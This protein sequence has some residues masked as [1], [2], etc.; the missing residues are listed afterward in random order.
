M[1]K[2]LEDVKVEYVSQY[3]SDL[4]KL[5]EGLDSAHRPKPDRINQIIETSASTLYVDDLLV[6]R[7]VGTNNLRLFD[8]PG[9]PLPPL[10]NPFPP[11]PNPFPGLGKEACILAHMAIAAAVLAAWVNSGGTLVVGTTAAGVTI[12][13]EIIAALIGGA[14]GRALAEKFC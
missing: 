2:A 6:R 14:T 11:L 10:P 9:I 13:N 1:M 8:F 7:F 4:K 5:L 12:T 3:K